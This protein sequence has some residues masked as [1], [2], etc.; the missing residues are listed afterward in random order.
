MQTDDVK[1][2]AIFLKSVRKKC[3]RK[4]LFWH[5]WLPLFLPAPYGQAPHM[6]NNSPNYL[7]FSK[8]NP[9]IC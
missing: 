9:F 1:V 8:L 6:T 3:Y 4:H 5:L 7:S 2:K